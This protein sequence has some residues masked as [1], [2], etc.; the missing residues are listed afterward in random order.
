ML[1]NSYPFLF[2]F[3][4]LA[5]LGFHAAARV[6]PQTAKIWLCAVSLVF[7]A[8]WHLEWL[9]LLLCSIVFNYGMSSQLRGEDLP[10]TRR[11]SLLLTAAITIN[12]LLLVYYKYLFSLLGFFHEQ[13]WLAADAGS[14]A[15]PIGISFFTFTQI[16]YLVDC[17]QGLVRERGFLEYLLFVSF[18]PHLTA[19][20]ILHHREVMPQFADPATYRLHAGNMAV[21]FTLFS[22]GLCKK[23]LLADS[24]VTWVDYGNAHLPRIDFVTAWSVAVAYSMQLYFDFSG[25]SDMAIG[26][27][28]LFA[29]RMPL[30]FNSPFKALSIIEFW[31]RWHITLTRYVTL[32]VYNPLSLYVA[33]RR[34]R[35]G[36]AVNRN[37]LASASGFAGMIAFPTMITTLVAGIWHAAGLQFVAYGALHGVYLC[38]NHVWRLYRKPLQ[39]SS[40]GRTAKTWSVF[41]RWLL[42]YLAVL[43][44]MVLFSAHSLED[45]GLLLKGMLGLNGP[46][47]PVSPNVRS[48]WF[49]VGILMGIAFGLPNIYQFLGTWSPALTAVRAL[50]WPA[51]TW[52]P[53][54]RYAMVFGLLL[55]AAALSSE[56]TV[57]FLYFQF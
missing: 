35:A 10:D 43:A 38:V 50:Q 27:G 39:T 45:A 14:V 12:L 41:W 24:I 40:L 29:V 34:Q 42:T 3:L 36:L 4:P 28:I 32:L 18:F 52:R 26:L 11:Q 6:G 54:L 9:I 49:Y 44:A 53:A 51:L 33:R 19:G 57:R 46:G 23:V 21:G 48:H 20:P 55:G 37:A 25:Y 31:Q 15:L 8:C 17:R 22:V 7:Y 47:F 2:L 30:N 5:L 56:R 13:G 16:G 1:F